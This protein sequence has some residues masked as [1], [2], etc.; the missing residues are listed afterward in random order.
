MVLTVW[1]LSAPAAL[2]G[3]W[4]WLLCEYHAD[5]VR[6]RQA[7]PVGRTAVRTAGGPAAPVR[8]EPY[9]C[10]SVPSPS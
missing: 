7:R 5:R 6:I 2:L 1:M 10:T 3:A 8:Y 4:V 9:V